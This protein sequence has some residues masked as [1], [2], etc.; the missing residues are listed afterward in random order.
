MGIGC[1]KDI[2]TPSWTA[3]KGVHL[4]PFLTQKMEIPDQKENSNDNQQIAACGLVLRGF[5]FQLWRGGGGGGSSPSTPTNTVPSISS[6]SPSATLVGGAAPTLTVNGTNFVAD[7]TVQVNGSNRTTT[8]VNATQLTASLTAA[9]VASSGTAPI[10]VVNP[11]PGGGTSGALNLAV[12]DVLANA[13]SLG[14]EMFADQLGANVNI[15]FLDDT[16]SAFIPFYQSAGVSLFRYPGGH[17]A[18]FY[19]WQTNTYGLCSPYPAP[20]ASNAF[21]SWM[22]STPIPVGAD[23]NITVNYETNPTCISLADPNEAAGWVNYANNT[24]H[25]GV[26]SWSVG[27][28]EYYWSG[29]TAAAY[30]SSV[31]TQF[32][33]LMKAQDST[34]QVGVSVAFGNATYA[35]SADTWDPVV[36]ANAQYDFVETHYTLIKLVPT[37]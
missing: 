26:K 36:L 12:S 17:L 24:Q 35:V 5:A 6:L 34:I 11:G 13:S 33:P 21:D 1:R 14:S 25:Y 4:V 7:S 3:K 8:Y 16:N 37:G 10:T 19:H 27:N 20:P 29:T 23:V 30:A 18:D 2:G 22:P 15:G 9:D 28:E 31:A 32:Y